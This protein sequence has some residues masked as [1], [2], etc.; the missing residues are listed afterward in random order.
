VFWPDLASMHYS[1]GT[2]DFMQTNG[3]DFMPKHMIPAAVPEDRA[4][5]TYW[6]HV[7]RELKKEPKGAKTYKE[8]K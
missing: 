1:K 2:I 7:K 8:L 6:G 5:E 3:I 4:I